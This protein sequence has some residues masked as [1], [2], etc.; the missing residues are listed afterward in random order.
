MSMLIG[1]ETKQWRKFFPT[2]NTVLGTHTMI[3][4][5][6]VIKTIDT[7]EMLGVAGLITFEENTLDYEKEGQ[8]PMIGNIHTHPF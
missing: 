5:P 1:N 7:N 3:D 6:F 2:L 8:H 4:H